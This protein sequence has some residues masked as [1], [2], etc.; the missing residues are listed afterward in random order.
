MNNSNKTFRSLVRPILSILL[1]IGSL[2]VI[3]QPGGG[4]GGGGGGGPVIC[5]D[6]VLA[7]TTGA[8][9]CGT[10]SVTLSASYSGSNTQLRWYANSSGGSLLHTGSTYSPTVSS[11]TT[12][13]VAVY[14]TQYNC[15]NPYRRFVTAT[16]NPKPAVPSNPSA[17]FYNCGSVTLTRSNPP[18][19]VTWYWQTSSSGTSTAN[20][21]VTT[22]GSAGTTYYLRG[23]NNTTLCWGD[24]RAVNL[25]V[26]TNPPAAP[27]VT[28]ATT[29]CSPANVTFTTTSALNKWYTSAS[30]GS[31][32]HTGSSYTTNIS[33]VT[34]Y[35]V[36]AVTSFGCVSTSRTSVTVNY[37]PTVYGGSIGNAQS[38]CYNGNPSALTNVSAASGGYNGYSYQ[39]QVSTNNSSWSNIS[40]A[41]GTTYNPGNLT[42]NRWYRRRVQSCN[43]TGYSNTIKVTVYSNLN[44]GSITG[45]QT[46]C[47]NGNPSTLGNAISASGS[48]GTIQY[49]WQY[50][51]NGTS[52]WTNV[53]GATSST[54]NPPALTANRWYRRRVQASTC[55]DYK[56]SNSIKIT[57][58]PI[59]NAGTISNAQ[60]LCYN[61]DPGTLTNTTS[62]SGSSGTIQ[63]QWQYSANGSSGW[64]NISGA[65][66][67]TY[68]P[69]ALTA[70]RWYRRRVRTSTCSEYKYTNS[71]KVTI[72][73]I[74]NAG[75]IGNAQTL[76]YNGD[77][78]SLTNTA[79]ATGSSGTIQY[80][81]QYSTNGSSGWTNISGATSS[82]YNPG[83][84]TADRWYR[85]RVRTS[86]CSE[87][88][89]T[90]SIKVTI[91]PILNA[92][93]IGNAQTLC[94]NGNPAALTNTTSATGSSGTIQYQWQYSTNGSSGWTDISGATS[95]TYNPGALTADRW[96]RRRV[97]TSTCSEYKY[98]N[99][100]KVTI[101]PI[102]NAGTIGNAQT[103]C[104]N[105]DP[106]ALTNT[107]SATGSSGTIQYQWQYSTNG[108]SGWTDISGAT[109]STYDPG[110]LT[111]SR[112]YRRR[113]RTSTCSEY[114]YTSSVKVTIHSDLSAGTIGNA[115]TLCY[116]GNPS[117]LTSTA[118]ASGSSGTYQYQW[119]YSANGS[120][121]WTNINGA[122]ST[123]YNP[124]A[125][126]V[127]RWYR[128]RVRTSTCS[129][130]KYTGS[131]KVTIHSDINAGT[132]GNAQT[133]CYNGN[134][135]AL[136]NTGSATGS[137]GTIQYQWQSSS[138]GSS[139]TNIS[140]ATSATYDPGTLIA[141]QWY[142]RGA[143]TSS[144]SA[145]NYTGSVKVTVY[146][147]LS[148]GSISNAQTVCYNGNP[149]SLTNSGSPTGGNSSYGYQWEYS[150]NGSSGWT[151]IS[152]ATAA[153]YD[154][155][156]LTSDRWYRRRVQSC[157]ETDYTGT[158]KVTVLDNLTAGS[159]GNAQ[160]ICY[161]SDPAVLSNTSAPT[162]GNSTFS[163]QWQ[164][165]PSGGS[166]AD[167]SGA[168]SSTY[169]PL[170]LT[171]TTEFRR[172]V[173]SCN[174][175][176][177][178]S[179][180]TVAVE[181]L[182]V[183]GAVSGATEIFV[184]GSGNLTLSGHNGT[185][186]KW[187]YKTTGSWIDIS[188]TT[189]GHNYVSLT[190][191]TRYRAQ[192]ENGTC[193]PAYS[194]EALVTI[195]SAP[196]ITTVSTT[197]IRPGQTTTLMA[198]AGHANYEWFK[199]NVTVQNGASNTLMVSE[200]AEYKV[201]VT[202]SGNATFTTD[203]IMITSQLDV[204][205]NAVVVSSFR[206]PV[207]E[208]NNIPP[209]VHTYTSDE[210]AISAD[211]YDGLGRVIQQVSLDASP[212][213]NDVV[214]PALYDELGRQARALLPYVSSD[215]SM[216]YKTDAI[217]SQA[218]FYV[219]EHGTSQA[220]SEQKFEASPMNRVIEQGNAGEAWKIGSEH[221]V[222]MD[223][224]I[225]VASEV[226]AWDEETL[227][228]QTIGYYAEGE[229]Y[230]NT[231][232]DEDGNQTSEFTD[233]QGR[234]ILKKSET[235]DLS[236]P[237]AE[238]YYIYDVLGQ[239]KTVIPPEATSRL[240]TEFFG[241]S[242]T[243]RT[244]FL[245]TWAFLYNYDYRARMTVKKVPGADSVFMVYDQ[246]NR[247]V[248]TQ[249]GNQRA[250]ATPEWLFTKYDYL[251]R[252]VMTGIMSS[253]DPETTIRDNVEV[254]ADRYESF[255][256]TEANQYT[257]VGYPDNSIADNYLT[258]TYYD[259]YDYQSHADWSTLGLTFDD[260]SNPDVLVQN[261]VVKGQV[262][263]TM[264]KAG[265]GSW[266][267]SVSY[268]DDKYRPIQSQSTNHLGG[269]DV[270]TNYYD[271]IGQVTRTISSHS[272]GT[273]TT[274]IER[275]F[276]YDHAGRLLKTWHQ[277]NDEDSVLVS[278][279]SYNELGELIEKNLHKDPP[280][281][282]G[283]GGFAQSVDYTY[284]IRGWLTSIND[285]GL[286]GVDGDLFGMELYYDQTSGLTGQTSLYNGNISAMQW[287]NHLSE[288]TANNDTRAYTYGYDKLN[289]L[290]KADHF[291]ES[292]STPK[293]GLS[294]LDYDLNG[295]IESLNRRSTGAVAMDSL[296][297]DYEGNQLLSV[298]D[299][300]LDSL[301]FYD[302]NTTGDDYAYDANGNMVK[303]LNKS[304][305]S[306]YYNH[307]NL[308][309]KVVFS[310]SGGGQ[311][312]DD[313]IEYLYDAAGIKLSQIVYE[314]GDTVK[315]TDYVGEFIY[316]TDTSGIRELQLIQ[317]EEGRIVKK[318]PFEGGQGDVW[319]YQYHLKDHLGNTRL[320]FSTT[321]ENYE[322]VATMEDG[323]EAANFTNYTATS[324]VVAAN[325]GTH[326]S[327]NANDVNSGLG[328][329]T[330]I[331]LNK[332]DTVK[333]D[334]YAYYN[335]AGSSYNLAANLIE[336]ALFS[337]F[338]TNYGGE[339]ATAT[340]TNFDD[341][342]GGGT[343]LGGRSETS[344]APHAFINYI[345]FDRDMVYQHAGFKQITSASNLASV[346][347]VADDFI[348]DQDGYIMVY[349]SNETT[350]TT[351]TVSWD[352]FTIYHGKTNIVQSDD[353]YP[354]GL[355]FNSYQRTASQKNFMNTFQNQEY[356]EETGWVKFKWRNHQPDIGR[357]FNVDP[358]AESYVYNSPYAF[359][360]ND[361][362][363]AIELEGLEK[364]RLVN[365]SPQQSSKLQS[366]LKKKNKILNTPVTQSNTRGDKLDKLDAINGEVS[367]I[368]DYGSGNGFSDSFMTDKL[369]ESGIHVPEEVKNGEKTT[370]VYVLDPDADFSMQVN[371][372]I[373]NEDG[374]LEETHLGDVNP[375][376]EKETVNVQ[377]TKAAAK[378][379]ATGLFDWALM[380]Y[381]FPRIQWPV[382]VQGAE[383]ENSEE[384]DPDNG[385]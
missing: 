6:P 14:S 204:S 292:T 306:I 253:D 92:G 50:S 225:N 196:A 192:V 182:S 250:A 23:R 137:S 10:G 295:N 251:N 296:D 266:I 248:L 115:Q 21:S 76:C 161:N 219:N 33:G 177:S 142:R 356:E 58:H 286:I 249:D 97:R 164:S 77:P 345:F 307:L 132:I 318:S 107:G 205:K 124:G 11:T 321:P 255:G 101:Y 257:N 380:H 300:A 173:T 328:M 12:Y 210:V 5:T 169:D 203:F 333:A 180:I 67:S 303:D 349:L 280:L 52:G 361:V 82:T 128:R 167:I 279:N 184:T 200:P 359:S 206:I 313:R 133:I 130:Y 158:I 347:V 75:T 99:S 211:I 342:F 216:I 20:S 244:A 37:Q 44:A 28:G 310:P 175:L 131:V 125:L 298:T 149:S 42:A 109:S 57:I 187:Q 260:P 87:Y 93:T 351:L 197:E 162:G 285:S 302:G 19:G 62:A 375:S 290:K 207:T 374:T 281:Q 140:G 261:T 29:L 299:D 150:N 145:L 376:R 73:P 301:G 154:P 147:S 16:V 278:E 176:A 25:T 121:G 143:N 199:D 343:D 309:I 127:D 355:V 193:A 221:T 270:V 314:A 32:F 316:E 100:I 38:V 246:W 377:T 232:F 198:T 381:G 120:S 81:W 258:V 305:D 262:T 64:T 378:T 155:G 3:A 277:L 185:V 39:W 96:Y 54:Y 202:S 239:L 222:T 214:I 288:A 365:F 358:L 312:E 55:S 156:I 43:K 40:G 72:H 114:K 157:G 293:Y 151:N 331:S 49:Q 119:Q 267:K 48:S 322:M 379:I 228:T 311:G 384:T 212:L 287:S 370:M 284:N 373:E 338:S 236:N 188:N 282:G 13:Y 371:G 178:S 234:T 26:D 79:S 7:Q 70:S 168:V 209:D 274:T 330:F 275:D 372:V 362:I 344:T 354:F 24:S 69:G 1:L 126:T 348:A 308:P 116:N 165:R 166:W 111:S 9:R 240:S 247:L 350:G 63:Y 139:W 191:S 383:N 80:Q 201:T 226:I 88:K 35:F 138:N 4:P 220:F 325:S 30:G 85:R 65:T 136:S 117:T 360:E 160:T 83:A 152:G 153:T 235:G 141:D 231:T 213:G 336:G 104:Y 190:E 89:Y 186:N 74:L 179:A 353:Y 382:G 273:D 112:W 241:Q 105:G 208:S 195:L 215:K 357:F 103:L 364:I 269:K 339:G 31:P 252:P 144:C 366:T 335:D 245:N 8:T 367:R 341:A 170:N 264:T 94:Y 352:D 317:H 268:Y 46:L 148:A 2:F 78:G 159:I 183:G 323:S 233:K 108:S 329:N 27:S 36:E 217:N 134:P 171:T 146:A 129:A 22:S 91:H 61:G 56:Y 297:Y 110:A 223:Y 315:V 84:L 17:S 229:L 259:D 238:T 189:A 340:Q 289:R 53:S 181:T 230:K 326:V 135:S 123:T 304:I 242:Q 47:Y 51:A 86:T 272:N 122:T 368:V 106:A 118:S 369:E 102:L 18:S 346:Q 263:G 194:A 41:T 319:D 71:V 172:Q 45:A 243:N 174:L 271:F 334:V 60:T 68:N 283:Q 59:L 254:E 95:S 256:A 113:V 163:Y 385:G 265:D 332:G 227:L 363:S 218:S 291:E 90:N 294:G 337:T 34:T 276:E 224:S 15:E 324:D 66:S 98:T 327:R 320:T 237:W